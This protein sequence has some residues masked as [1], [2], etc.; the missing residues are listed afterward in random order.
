MCVCVFSF[1]PCIFTSSV[2]HCDS[3][4]TLNSPA[5]CFTGS[6]R[7]KD[8]Q[9]HVCAA[10][11]QPTR[12]WQSVHPASPAPQRQSADRQEVTDDGGGN[13]GQSAGPRFWSGEDGN[14]AVTLAARLSPLQLTCSVFS[15]R[16]GRR[17]RRYHQSL[18]S[19]EKGAHHVHRHA[20]LSADAI[21]RYQSSHLHV[22]PLGAESP[23][24]FSTL[25][26]AC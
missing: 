26:T 15:V 3:V 7:H 19:C 12:P 16:G 24:V 5:V 14:G 11:S 13:L 10:G 2:S 17:V 1:V 18:K 20:S 22:R 6:G 21:S 9:S 4:P 23:S 25:P 8:S